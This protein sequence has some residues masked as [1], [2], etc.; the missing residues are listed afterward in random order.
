MKHAVHYMCIACTCICALCTQVI[1]TNLLYRQW[2]L[3][4]K[5][6]GITGVDCTN[7]KAY[8]YDYLAQT[9]YT[10]SILATPVRM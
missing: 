1:N 7:F 4:I 2:D 3:R 6:G 5:D 10:Y 9:K 8:K